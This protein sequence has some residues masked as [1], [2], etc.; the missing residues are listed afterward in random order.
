MWVEKCNGVLALGLCCD[1]Y[2]LFREQGSRKSE[3]F[4]SKPEMR[5]TLWQKFTADASIEY[6][7]KIDINS[8]R[9]SNKVMLLIYKKPFWDGIGTQDIYIGT[10]KCSEGLL[11]LERG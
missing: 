3:A 10:H 8:R 7:T 6:K 11:H 5:F 4:W 2:W 1:F 9:T